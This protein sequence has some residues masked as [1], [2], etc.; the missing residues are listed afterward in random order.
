MTTVHGRGPEGWNL[1][2]F[3]SALGALAGWSRVEPAAR[4]SWRH[5][6]G[7]WLPSWNLPGVHSDEAAVT[8]LFQALSGKRDGPLLWDASIFDNGYPPSPGPFREWSLE[9]R[10]S[11]APANRWLTD[12]IVAL[13]SES[14]LVGDTTL[15]DTLLRTTRAD[16][17]GNHGSLVSIARS[18]L[19]DVREDHLRGTLLETWTYRDEDRNHSLRWDPGEHR[20]YAL[21]GSNPSSD[22]TKGTQW[23]AN[24]LALEA[25][26]YFPTWPSSLSRL[27]T[28][29]FVRRGRGDFRMRWPMWE[30]P[31][32]VAE[33][34]PLLTHPAMIQLGTNRGTFD[35]LGVTEV[36]ESRRHR[37][38]Y[39]RNF[40]PGEPQLG[41]L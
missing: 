24:R 37:Q 17:G 31:L 18:L 30:T 13:G 11:A 1:L 39:Y 22:R 32:S 35:A 33:I 12:T 15:S 28:T 9:A 27:D 26:P 34:R 4:L 25:L 29:A 7:T 19:A 36:Y 21:R 41:L 20:Q 40:T 6:G 10:R 14:V 8:L 5:H 23:G 2:G 3:L 38:E 16:R